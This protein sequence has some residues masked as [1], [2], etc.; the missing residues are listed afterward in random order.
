MSTRGCVAFGTPEKWRGVYNHFDSYPTGLGREVWE[1]AIVNLASPAN[2]RGLLVWRDK[3][4]NFDDW[5]AY[6]AGGIC[7]YCGKPAG[8]PHSINGLICAHAGGA[9]PLAELEREYLDK[10]GPL[11]AWKDRAGELLK[12]A[13]EHWQIGENVRATGYP[14]PDAKYHQHNEGGARKQQLTERRC[15]PLFIE[16]IYIIDPDRQEMHVVAHRDVT[17][18]GYKESIRP[19]NN[20]KRLPD[21][22]VDYGHCV[23]KHVLIKTFDLTKD[24]PAW[25][26]LEQEE[27]EAAEAEYSAREGN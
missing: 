27:N 11:P 1:R 19:G 13:Q 4:L 12:M 6:L 20:H 18:K 8:Q 24:E 7:E 9:R 10:Y 22:S 3:V 21:G 14:D 25:E 2:P 5:R 26:K 17:P 16:W 15:D 23:Y